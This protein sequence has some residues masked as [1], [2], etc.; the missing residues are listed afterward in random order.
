MIM[1]CDRLRFLRQHQELSQGEA[2]KRLNLTHATYCRYETGVHQPDFDTL[3]KIANF[4]DVSIDYLLENDRC[5]SDDA[6]IVDFNN[7]IL[8]GRYTIHSKF[9]TTRERKRLNNIVN[10]VYDD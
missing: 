4:F 1:F 8:N 6:E 9:L 3:K 10:A 7:F 2:A 5:L